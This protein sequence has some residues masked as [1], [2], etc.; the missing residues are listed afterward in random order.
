[1]PN[2]L[3]NAINWEFLDEPMYRWFL[4]VGAFLGILWAW[5]GIIDLMK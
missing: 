4:A 1:M 5:N 2:V 3:A